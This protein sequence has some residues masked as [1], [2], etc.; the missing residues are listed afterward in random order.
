MDVKV[1]KTLQ[2][3]LWFDVGPGTEGGS[4]ALC[5]YH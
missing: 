5:L 3:G 2:E 1:R 4:W